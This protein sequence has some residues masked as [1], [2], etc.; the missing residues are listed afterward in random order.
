MKLKEYLLK[1][2]QESTA[3]SYLSVINTY[4]DAVGKK[5]AN[6]ADYQQIMNYLGELRNQYSNA[7][8][9]RC[10][11][12][13][14]K[15][16][17]K[18]LVFRGVRIDN[19]CVS[20]NLKDKKKPIQLQDLFT[21]QELESL[22]QRKERF[23]LLEIRNKVVVS[24]LIYQGLH[25][26]SIENLRLK[27]IHLDKG[28]IYIRSNPIT[29]SRTLPLKSIQ[30]ALFAKY[31]NEV[32]PKLLGR[33]KREWFIVASRGGTCFSRDS[34]H[35]LISTYKHLFPDRKLCPETIRQSF[36]T[37]QIKEGK[38]L[39]VVQVFVGMK[40]LASIEFYQQRNL[41]E[42]QSEINKFHPLR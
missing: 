38:D 13:G 8:T 26:S 16:Y 36:I 25:A 23:K 31:L 1:H 9:I 20:I 41:E 42:L 30:V 10:H 22:L 28:E 6:R 15:K 11:L 24:L 14:I 39:R 4:L 17:Y 7:E 34:V 18:Y 33:M 12:A 19:P 40:N 29:N 35:Y 21:S 32:R 27:D 2:N 37:N 5:E 3:K